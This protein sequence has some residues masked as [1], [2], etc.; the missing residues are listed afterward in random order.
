MRREEKTDSYFYQK[1]VKRFGEALSDLL[2]EDDIPSGWR[3]EVEHLHKCC[4]DLA[5]KCDAHRASQK[6]P[7]EYFNMDTVI[8]IYLQLIY[9]HQ[10]DRLAWYIRTAKK[11]FKRKT[12]E[13]LEKARNG[14]DKALFELIG[15]DT[16][17]RLEPWI[18][19]KAD[20]EFDKGNGHF[21]SAMGDAM[22]DQKGKMFAMRG[23]ADLMKQ[24]KMRAPFGH[25]ISPMLRQFLSLKIPQTASELYDLLLR[26]GRIDPDEKDLDAFEKV[27]ER[28]P[29]NPTISRTLVS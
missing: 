29:F 11:K 7:I 1:N 24:L 4:L 23:N 3:N 10:L 19:E 26:E 17:W 16:R 9:A 5:P 6:G 18:K 8:L 14:S 13:I 2:E 20:K 12:R 25:L 22:K 28:S 15:F 27:I 21:I